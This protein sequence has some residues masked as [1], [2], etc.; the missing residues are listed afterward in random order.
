MYLILNCCLLL[1][2]IT[3]TSLQRCSVHYRYDSFVT[4]G[5]SFNLIFGLSSRNSTIIIHLYKI[6]KRQGRNYITVKPRPT[7]K[8]G[9]GRGKAPVNEDGWS[10]CQSRQYLL[11]AKPQKVFCTY[12]P[13][14]T[15][16]PS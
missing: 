13:L 7:T 15:A 8:D 3:I 1:Q 11:I 10:I 6:D 14:V 4:T 9:N 5:K 12:Q 16:T 2:L